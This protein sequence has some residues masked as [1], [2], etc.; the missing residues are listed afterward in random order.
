[1]S[2]MKQ[3]ALFLDRDGTLVYPEHYPSR[4]EQ[5]RLYEGLGTSLR[6]L[7][8]RGFCPVVITNQSG[9]AMGY[10]TAADL[11][12]MHNY[13]RTELQFQGVELAGIYYCPH[14]PQGKIAELAIVCECRKP[15]PGL[16]L[17]AAAA[18]DIDLARSWFIGDILDDVEAGRRAGCSTI[19][20]D[21]GTEARPTQAFRTPDFVARTTLHALQI[22]QSIEGGYECVDLTY[23]PLS[24]KQLEGSYDR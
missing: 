23:R 16:L 7:Q 8:D 9:L 20:V 18:L 3:R 21:L 24:W 5:L 17:Q 4:P 10:F 1:M 19:L 15:R 12:R 22:I 6:A 13:L 14:H 2:F 11:E